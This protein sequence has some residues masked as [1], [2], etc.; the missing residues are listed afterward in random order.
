MLYLKYIALML[1]AILG[2]VIV[3]FISIW[4]CTLGTLGPLLGV[5]FYLAGFCVLR[6][7]YRPYMQP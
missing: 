7:L 2:V 6:R 3:V 1:G 4:L 5:V